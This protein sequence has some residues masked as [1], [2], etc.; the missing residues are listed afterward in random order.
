MGMMFVE[1]TPETPSSDSAP[2]QSSQR[3]LRVHYVLGA[4]RIGARA[5][6]VVLIL[7]SWSLLS[8][9]E[10]LDPNLV[11]SPSATLESMRYL[12]L[13]AEG[14]AHVGVSLGELAGAFGMTLLIGIPL[15]FA[16]GELGVKRPHI[17]DLG[18]GVM[19]IALATP[20]FIF[21][22]IFL[23]I[24][25]AS[26]WQK[27]AYIM[28]EGI[29][30]LVLAMIAAA[31]EVTQP[32]RLLSKSAGAS[33]WQHFRFFYLPAVVPPVVE[34][35]RIA[36]ILMMGGVLL[37]EMFISSAGI[38]HLMARSGQYYDL[39]GL[40]AAVILVGVIVTVLNTVFLFIERR[41]DAWRVES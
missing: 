29:I 21:L 26:Y 36:T 9:H 6:A 35:L 37:A 31:S 33:R 4:R 5:G 24:F 39:A 18:N 2:T 20:K 15:G 13:D 30:I 32:V 25:G 12:L 34:A 11:P 17:A 28:L 41:T 10:L 1:A 22:P 27:V 8:E 7:L 3:S 16:L 23:A 40:F 38:G 14:L 19:I